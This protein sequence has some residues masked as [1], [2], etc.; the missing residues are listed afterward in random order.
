MPA[1]AS[2]PSRVNC[3]GMRIEVFHPSWIGESK[4][5]NRFL[6]HKPGSDRIGSLVPANFRDGPRAKIETSWRVRQNRHCWNRRTRHTKD[7]L[8]VLR[9]DFKPSMY[10]N[11]QALVKRIVSA[12]PKFEVLLYYPRHRQCK[13]K[14]KSM[15]LELFFDR[16]ILTQLVV[17]IMVAIDKLSEKSPGRIPHLPDGTPLGAGWFFG[18]TGRADSSVS[19]PVKART[20]RQNRHNRARRN[21]LPLLPVRSGNSSWGETNPPGDLPPPTIG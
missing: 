3:R 16:M 18:R 2:R 5:A 10:T 21:R 15:F 8:S 14:M 9:V 13:L 7:Q 11:E 17:W 12:R 1:K 6:I 4:L 19:A 20:M